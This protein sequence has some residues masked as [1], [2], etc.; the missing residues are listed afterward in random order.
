M[1]W[2]E[3]FCSKTVKNRITLVYL[4]CVFIYSF[5]KHIRK[6]NTNLI[7]NSTV[8]MNGMMKLFTFIFTRSNFLIESTQL[9]V[10]YTIIL[11]A[12]FFQPTK[13]MSSV[14][15]F[16]LFM[17]K[18]FGQNFIIFFPFVSVMLHFLFAHWWHELGVA[19]VFLLLLFFW[20][21]SL[22][23]QCVSRMSH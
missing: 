6:T 12:H 4:V 19:G 9:F 10:L 8:S 5:Q 21:S 14:T 16:V 15:H 7:N 2:A 22:F 1:E 20:L 3:R 18:Y 13:K 17:F 23:V 11:N